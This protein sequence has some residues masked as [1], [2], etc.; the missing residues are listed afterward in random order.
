M[1]WGVGWD[2]HEKTLRFSDRAEERGKEE[3]WVRVI[4]VVSLEGTGKAV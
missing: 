2:P 1:P 4:T 3:L